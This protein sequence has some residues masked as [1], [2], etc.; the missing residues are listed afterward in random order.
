MSG[1]FLEVEAKFR[2]SDLNALREKLKSLEAR[3]LG[4]VE[5]VDVYMQHPCRNFAETDEAL[6]VRFYTSPEGKQRSVEITYKGPRQE[7]WAKSRSEISAKAE[8]FESVLEI[9][10][11]MGF[12]EVARIV[13]RREFYE[14]ENVEISLD[15]V[16]ELGYFVELE[17][18]GAGEAV[19]KSLAEKLG[20]T[21]LVPETYLELYLRK[22]GIL[23]K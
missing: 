6:R 10:R 1:R 16:E 22:K 15:S 21:E 2:C 18:R 23:V 11:R 5:M 17:D 9:F 12:A 19:L 20:L 7:G 14:L 13:K 8:D 3:L 4:T